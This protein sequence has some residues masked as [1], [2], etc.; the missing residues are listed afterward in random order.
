M[1]SSVVEF[2][3]SRCDNSKRR[4]ASSRAIDEYVK[5]IQ[6]D[7]WQEFQN[8]KQ[9]KYDGKPVFHLQSLIR[10]YLLGDDR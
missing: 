7:V 4:C 6:V 10:T 1:I 3:I 8:I 2:K 9:N 5:D